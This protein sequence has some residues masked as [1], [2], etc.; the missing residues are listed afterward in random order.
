MYRSGENRRGRRPQE[1]RGGEQEVQKVAV[2]GGGGVGLGL[3]EGGGGR[4]EG[5]ERLCYM[6]PKKRGAWEAAE[7]EKLALKKKA[8]PEEDGAEE[9][10]EILQE[11]VEEVIDHQE[12]KVGEVQNGNTSLVVGQ[13]HSTIMAT[14]G[15]SPSEMEI[16]E[17]LHSRQLAVYGRETMR[18]LFG[19]RVLIS[20][21]QG[22]GAEIGLL[23]CIRS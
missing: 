15:G 12:Q 16:D 21:L 7:L 17:D 22:L 19:A 6:L 14:D 4:E 9:L 10:K 23:Q 2:E 8:K 11:V 18:R 20:G 1:G 3:G 13:Q 5:E